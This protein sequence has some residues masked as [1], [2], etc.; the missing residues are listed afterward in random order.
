MQVE[1]RAAASTKQV[2]AGQYRMQIAVAPKG[3]V[4]AAMEDLPF[5]IHYSLYCSRISAEEHP[6]YAEMPT[7]AG[8]GWVTVD[9]CCTCRCYCSW[10]GRRRVHCSME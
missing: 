4:T 3:S 7:A 10:E 1:D 2:V 6:Y 9:W 8:V 5:R